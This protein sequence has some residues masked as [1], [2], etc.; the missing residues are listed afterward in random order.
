MNACKKRNHIRALHQIV[1]FPLIRSVQTS[2]ISL[3]SFMCTQKAKFVG[4]WNVRVVNIQRFA[5]GK[6]D[7]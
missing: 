4:S 3:K 1:L 5:A 7:N 6:F 2:A